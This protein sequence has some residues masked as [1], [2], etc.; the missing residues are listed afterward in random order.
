MSNDAVYQ[1]VAAA[2]SAIAAIEPLDPSAASTLTKVID[3]LVSDLGNRK[4]QGL[5]KEIMAQRDYFME[6]AQVKQAEI[7]KAHQQ[8]LNSSKEIV[9]SAQL[10]M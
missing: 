3:M 2:A 7:E 10:R 9:N 8:L 6:Q 1:Y 5:L 4:Q